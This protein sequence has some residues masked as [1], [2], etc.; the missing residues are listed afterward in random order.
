MSAAARTALEPVRRLG[1]S[2][3][4]LLGAAA[5]LAALVSGAARIGPDTYW[6]IGAGRWILAHARVPTHDPFS[7]TMH[8]APWV[9]QEWGAEV[10]MAWVYGMA[11]WSGLVLMIAAL[12]ALSIAYLAH[13]L[14]PRMEPLHTVLL[15]VLGA[16]MMFS[17]ILVRP[18]Q[19][20]WPLTALWVGVLIDAAEK[21]A[22]PPWW[23]LAVMLLWA[24]L[25]ASFI[26][27]LALAVPIGIEAV[28]GT[29]PHWKPTARRWGAFIAAAFGCALLNPQGYR[30]LIY[31][32]RVLGMHALSHL[33]EWQ[34]PNF[35]QLHVFALWLLALLALAF[36]G[37]VRLPL[38][39]SVLLVG[40][41]YFALQH[42][43]NVSLLGLLS[44]F[45]IA[46]P[47]ARL[48]RERAARAGDAGALDRGFRALARPAGRVAVWAAVVLAG[49]LGVAAVRLRKPG[50]PAQFTPRAALDALLARRPDARILN[51]YNFGGYLIFRGVPVFVD[52]RTDMY[53]NRFVQSY[54]DAVELAPNGNF[55]A[56][57][58]KY[59]IDAILMGPQW[60][61]VRLLDR[62]PQWRRVYADKVAVA[63]VRQGARP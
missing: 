26:L 51:D 49:A 55:L 57:L 42:I 9:A 33:T 56:L 44:P 58:K 24:N 7:F 39:R 60:P 27:G 22:A 32:F 30:L 19:I 53:G 34:Q 11:G 36:A 63:Y 41:I 35:Q 52:G 8:G 20:V 31:P 40:L 50:L 47:L 4:L 12:F 28:L 17:Y 45:L 38:L 3:P 5:F 6:H 62:L 48:W 21:R 54:F 29:K 18:Q 37:R 1:V 15:T 2:W 61:V 59:R 16:C 25:H 46:S 14:L 23:L 10:L 13:F 43:R